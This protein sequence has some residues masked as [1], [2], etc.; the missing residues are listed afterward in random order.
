MLYE[1]TCDGSIQ[2]GVNHRAEIL[3][4]AWKRVKGTKGKEQGQRRRGNVMREFGDNMEEQ[5]IV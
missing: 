4:S 2:Y 3:L 1:P 5:C